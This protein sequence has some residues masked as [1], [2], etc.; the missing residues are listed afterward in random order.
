[1]KGTVLRPFYIT[2]SSTQEY[3]CFILLGQKRHLKDIFQE[4]RRRKRKRSRKEEE[5]KEGEVRGIEEKV[6][7]KSINV[8]CLFLN[9][10]LICKLF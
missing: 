10:K 5:E 9:Y 8:F 3:V 1:M 2:A 7:K 4:K 6:K